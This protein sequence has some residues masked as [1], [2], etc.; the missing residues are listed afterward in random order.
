[1]SIAPEP[2]DWSILKEQGAVVAAPHRELLFGL[3]KAALRAEHGVRYNQLANKPTGYYAGRR[4]GFVC[5]A[6]QLM[7]VLYGGDYEAAKKA[8][9]FG[10]KAAGEAVTLADLVNPHTAEALAVTIAESALLVV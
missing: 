5:S 1:M 10:L 6:A 2:N 3:I 9:S 7:E 4:A 8:L